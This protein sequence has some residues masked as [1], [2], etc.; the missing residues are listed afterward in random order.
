MKDAIQSLHRRWRE[1][2]SRSS[3]Q[4]ILSLSFTAVAVVG[5]VGLGLALFLRF[6]SSNNTQQ[7]ENSQRVLTQV[8]WNLD[9]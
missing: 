4:M 8:N 5:L 6:S 9:A 7:A 3:I 1:L 2:Y